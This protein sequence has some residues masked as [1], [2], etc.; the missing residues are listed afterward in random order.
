MPLTAR[1]VWGRRWQ[2]FD[3]SEPGLAAY[4]PLDEGGGE[5]ALDA[6]PHKLHGLVVGAPSW[7]P[8]FAKPLNDVSNIEA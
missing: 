1:D 8:A 2:H 7:V 4:W 5:A 3:G 6:G